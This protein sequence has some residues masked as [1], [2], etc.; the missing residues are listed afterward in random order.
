VILTHSFPYI[1]F[2]LG[3]T[4]EL[5]SEMGYDKNDIDFIVDE[6]FKSHFTLGSLRSQPW[7]I[8]GIG[9]RRSRID[10]CLY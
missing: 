1:H 3:A 4:K 6:T 10:G 5:S 2:D 8:A 9:D 7:K